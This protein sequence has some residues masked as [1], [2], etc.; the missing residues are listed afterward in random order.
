V[1]HG[2]VPC[3]RFYI[4]QCL[5]T[6]EVGR[7]RFPHRRVSALPP[8]LPLETEENH[9]REEDEGDHQERSRFDMI[10]EHGISPHWPKTA[11]PIGV[12]S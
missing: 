10:C 8:A 5:S 12:I 9:D 7:G 4:G 6:L 3:R 11:S 1:G 2:T